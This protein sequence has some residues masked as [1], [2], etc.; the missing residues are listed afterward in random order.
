MKDN[1]EVRFLDGDRIE[2]T[3]TGSGDSAVFQYYDDDPELY[4]VSFH[5]ERVGMP[6]S[7][8]EVF[9]N[10]AEKEVTIRQ[11]FDEFETEPEADKVS[12]KLAELDKLVAENRISEAEALKDFHDWD[13]EVLSESP[14]K[15]FS[16]LDM[17]W[18]LPPEMEAGTAGT[19]FFLTSADAEAQIPDASRKQ[20]EALCE[21]TYSFRA[22]NPVLLLEAPR[23]ENAQPTLMLYPDTPCG[24]LFLDRTHIYGI[25]QFSGL[26]GYFAT[27]WNTRRGPQFPQLYL[28]EYGKM[29]L[30]K[31]YA[32]NEK[33]ELIDPNSQEEWY[34]FF[35]T[36]PYLVF[37]QHQE[38][39]KNAEAVR[40]HR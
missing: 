25:I 1:F 32:L 2:V 39:R 19:R 29:L 16:S 6:F 5:Y 38:F 9:F 23:D 20:V 21:T 11:Y 14:A 34:S 7:E 28:N 10:A 8:L 36:F 3:E 15:F 18:M 17:R 13:V 37:R 40:R 26:K 12:S 30:V 33:D 22:G 31:K 35:N 4:M 24:I 27:E